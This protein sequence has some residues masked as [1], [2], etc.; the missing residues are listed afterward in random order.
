[1]SLDWMQSCLELEAMEIDF[2][3]CQRS[4]KYTQ[5]KSAQVQFERMDRI[6]K[7]EDLNKKYMELENHLTEIVKE[8]SKRK[9]LRLLKQ[10]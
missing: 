3:D 1:M 8:E 7:Y 9:G 5:E 4:I 10:S 6:R 2:K